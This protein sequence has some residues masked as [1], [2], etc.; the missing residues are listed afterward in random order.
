MDFVR[1]KSKGKYSILSVLTFLVLLIYTAEAAN[2]NQIFSSP[3]IQL[4]KRICQNGQL[5]PG[6]FNGDKEM[7]LICIFNDGYVRIYLSTNNKYNR[8][9]WEGESPAACAF[10]TKGTRY[11]ADF[12]GDGYDDL[13]CF[14]AVNGKTTVGLYS[15]SEFP[16]ELDWVGD[17]PECKG[18]EKM[19]YVFDVNGDGKADLACGE[20]KK[21]G[22]DMLFLNE[23]LH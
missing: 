23:F 13:F 3:P 18:D 7:D 21:K 16:N 10:S 8:I 15:G 19:T 4:S 22:I 17:I 1:K 12:D 5:F 6:N 9:F 14:D 20:K 11:V 2:F